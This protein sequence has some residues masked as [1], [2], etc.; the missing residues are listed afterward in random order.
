MS[1]ILDYLRVV[2]LSFGPAGG[3]ATM[4][5]GDF[6][7]DVIKVEPAD[8][9]PERSHPAS[10]MWLRGKRS[11]VLDPNAPE[12]QAKLKELVRTADVVIC[13]EPES[14]ARRQG[15]DYATLSAE[16][17][18]LIYCSVTAWGNKGP[19]A[20]YP[21]DR[22]LVTA[23]SG[24]MASFSGISH[25]E[26][27]AYAAVHSETHAAAQSAIAGVLA[28]VLA[29]DVTGKGQFIETSLLQ[30]TM[31]YDMQTMVRAQLQERFPD[32][33]KDDPFARFSVTSQP[34]LGYQPIMGSDGQWIQL[35]NLLEHLFIA[36]IEALDLT[37][38]VLGDPRYATAP[39]LDPEAAEEVRNMMLERARTRPAA[40]WMKAF[41]ENGNVAAELVGTAQDGLK[42]A[43][44]IANGEIL[45]LPTRQFGTVTQLGAVARLTN[46]PASIVGDVPDIGQHTDEVLGALAPRTMPVPDAAVAPLTTGG[47]GRPPLEGIT[48]LEFATIIAAP[49]G[50]SFLADFG[51][52][53][54]K[55]EPV[56]GGDPM[57][58]FGVGLGAYIGASKT[59]AGKESIC[60]DL[61]AAEGQEI[62]RR[63]LE[64]ADVVIHNYRPGVPE[65]LG[66]GYEMARELNPGI[67]YVS[68]NGYQPDGPSARRPCA[69]PIPGAVNGGALLQAGVAWPP[70]TSTI[71]GIREAA[72]QYFRA[73]E[74]NP[75]PNTS[76]VVTTAAMLGL[77]A[78]RRT[79]VGQQIFTSMLGANGY[80]NYD[81]FLSFEGKW[82]TRPELDGDL[83]G[84][85]ACYRL[86]PS[87]DGWV[88]L[89]IRSDDEWQRFCLTTGQSDLGADARLA[90]AAGRME[91]DSSLSEQLAAIFAT[92]DSLDW[93][94]MLIPAGVGCV[95]AQSTPPGDFY[96][97][98][99][100]MRENGFIQEADHQLWGRYFR[101]GPN[102][103]F[104]DTPGRYGP[105]VLAGAN[106]DALLA[107]VGYSAD[108]IAVLRAMAVVDHT[109]PMELP[110]PVG[111]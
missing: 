32:A 58:N 109:E 101:H 65:R 84:L 57:R 26:G 23:K 69:H 34:T 12:D 8:G 7:A 24:R 41:H 90:T 66:I 89:A 43:D 70:D 16:N 52:R 17:P 79:G 44:L 99:P 73:N 105:G 60:I 9:D 100:Q 10:V 61:K 74:A 39:R 11:V 92:R 62:V 94:R 82:Q 45:D 56:G 35:A 95:Q 22:G 96:L 18:Q 88:F 77:A 14:I 75:D 59:N 97:N 87:A 53:V 2:D 78:R 19:Y 93:E 106:T 15:R 55:V 68:A 110:A 42:N 104:A 64:Q 25:R 71:E 80:A 67:I 21:A 36:S 98:D 47:N 29:R 83:H 85:G 111:V 6:G 4:V 20:E 86:Y 51:A 91:H 50:A 13:S 33:M 76:M 102:V 49:L 54:I 27:P 31:P 108:E 30:G 103:A 38:E 1:G 5:L 37:V 28:S 107:E 40:E 72:R 81:D 3:V 48:V 63:L 46:T